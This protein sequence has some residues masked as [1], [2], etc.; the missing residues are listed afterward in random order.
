MSGCSVHA[1]G[2]ESPH[3]GLGRLVSRAVVP[4]GPH[5]AKHYA[6]SWND[7][8][9]ARQGGES[10][11]QLSIRAVAAITMLVARPP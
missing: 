1:Q 2:P 10:L 11:V 4:D 9:T 3:L 6:A 8:H 7:P 5:F